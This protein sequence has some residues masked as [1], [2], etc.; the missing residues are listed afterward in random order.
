MP[1]FNSIGSAVSE[2]LVQAENHYLPLTGGIALTTVYALR[3]YAVIE[4][5]VVIMNIQLLPHE[6]S[7]YYDVMNRK[8]VVCCPTGAVQSG[9]EKKLHK[10]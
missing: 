2:P 7:W 8:M 1:N 3:C 6:W 4:F 10:V 9:P 5:E